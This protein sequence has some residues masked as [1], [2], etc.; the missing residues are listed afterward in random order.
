MDPPEHKISFTVGM[1]LFPQQRRVTTV[2]FR[3]VLGPILARSKRND[4]TRKRLS[5]SGRVAGSADDVNRPSSIPGKIDLVQGTVALGASLQVS[6]T[7]RVHYNLL[8]MRGVLALKST[9][10]P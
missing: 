4:L 10:R 9:A 6:G 7:G 3:L 5:C 2:S 8:A 1:Q